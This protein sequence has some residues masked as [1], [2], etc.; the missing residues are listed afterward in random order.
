MLNVGGDGQLPTRLV[1]SGA[2][3]RILEG[4]TDWVGSVAVSPDG[5][6]VV[7]GSYDESVRVWDA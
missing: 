2:C 7:S 3:V 4:H 5:R 6:R 1:A